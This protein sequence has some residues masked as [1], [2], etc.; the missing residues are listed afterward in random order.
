MFLLLLMAKYWKI[1]LTSGHSKLKANFALTNEELT[2]WFLPL[3]SQ[4]GMPRRIHLALAVPPIS[5][6][7]KKLP[8]VYIYH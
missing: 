3:I 7:R 5:V 4:D 8:N 1:I 2:Q 6:T